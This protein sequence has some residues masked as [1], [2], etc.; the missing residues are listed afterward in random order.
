MGSKRRAKRNKSQPP[1]AVKQH[2]VVKP[3]DP[4]S[5]QTV[6]P[7]IKRD[8]VATSKNEQPPSEID[9]IL[10]VGVGR[11]DA[12]GELRCGLKDLLDVL[13]NIVL[14][15]GLLFACV[16]AAVGP[17]NPKLPYDSSWIGIA[18]ILPLTLILLA[19][20]GQAFLVV[21]N[22]L[23]S[24]SF[25]SQRAKALAFVSIAII[26]IGIACGMISLVLKALEGVTH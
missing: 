8:I 23:Q 25:R 1:S 16:S 9:R 3:S 18:G 24:C 26:V 14:I 10:L 20:M 2:T 5:E 15:G 7:D 13:K 21:D 19:A 6:S 4:R 17:R 11:A 12:S 22:I